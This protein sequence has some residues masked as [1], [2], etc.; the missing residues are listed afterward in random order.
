MIHVI[1]IIAAVFTLVVQADAPTLVV[2]IV[3][4]HVEVVLVVVVV[5]VVGDIFVIAVAVD[6]CLRKKQIKSC[7]Y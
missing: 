3:L 7:Y 2:V 5:L 1:N 4:L 6:P